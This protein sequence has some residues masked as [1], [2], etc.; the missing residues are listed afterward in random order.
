[1]KSRKTCKQ[2]VMSLRCL[3][4]IAPIVGSLRTAH[5]EW[6]LEAVLYFI[7]MKSSLETSW[8]F[9]SLWNFLEF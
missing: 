9:Q 3:K 7:K 2:V 1:M 4:A 5:R 6:R 8:P